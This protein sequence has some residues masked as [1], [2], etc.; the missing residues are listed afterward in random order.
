[1]NKS[2]IDPD[3][4]IDVVY[5]AGKNLLLH[6]G[7]IDQLAFKTENAAGGVT[8]L[9]QET[10]KF[11]ES[12]LKKLYPSIG[13]KG[14]EF[15]SR[16]E[17]DRF[18]LVDPI[19]GTGFF[20]RGIQGCTTML[21]LIEEGKITFSIIYDFV[22]DKLYHAQKGEGALVNKTPVRVSDRSLK[23][24]FVHV[25]MNLRHSENVPLLLAISKVCIN[26]GQYPSGIHYAFIA[27]GKIDGKICKDPF[28][29]DYD[30]APGQLLVMEA[31]GVVANLGTHS[32]D[33]KNRDF[34]AVNKEVYKELTQTIF[35]IRS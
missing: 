1:M 10:E 33:Y 26:L 18:W 34:L 19:D 15:G 23:N 20:S 35:P 12:E 14:E 8:L 32:F 4:I 25:E 6:F 31:G 2:S 3:K 29:K 27:E 16:I 11:L 22:N 24:A 9:D 5:R 30:F 21:A 28:G 13:F 17:Q 7:N